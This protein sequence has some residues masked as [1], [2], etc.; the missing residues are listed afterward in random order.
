MATLLYSFLPLLV[1]LFFSNFSKSFSTDEAIK[2]FIFRVDSQSKPSIFP[3][4]YH[5]YT[6]EFAEPTRILHTFDTVFHGFSACLTETHA[7]SLS[8]HPLVLAVF[9]NRHRQLHTTCSSQFLGLRNQHGLCNRKLI[10]ARFFSKVHEATVGPGGPID[11]I[12]ETV[13]FMSPKDANGQGTCTASTAAGKHAFRSSMGGYAA[14]I[15]KGVAPKARLAVYKVCWKSSG[16]FDFDILAAFDAAVNDVVDVISISVGGGD[17]ISTT[18]HL[19]PIAIG[20]Y[21]AVSPEV[22]VSSSTGNDG[23][24]LM[25]VTNLAHWLVTVRAGTID[26]NFSADVI[27]SDGRRLNSV[28]LY[29]D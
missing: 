15:A 20:A 28:S 11:G 29:S 4:H 17:G 21:G 2:T 5:W 24:N 1:L 7:A 22:F 14:G 10:G 16:C 12:N 19:D 27:L 6:S 23:P 3:T 13:E 9:E 18:Y 26:R 25:S 8:N